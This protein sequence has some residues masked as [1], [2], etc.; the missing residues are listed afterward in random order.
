M[1]LVSFH[2]VVETNFAATIGNRLRRAY[3]A[4]I[5]MRMKVAILLCFLLIAPGLTLA[6]SA[7]P[8][9]PAESDS[10]V[11]VLVP[12]GSSEDEPEAGEEAAS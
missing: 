2:T 10:G 6:Q 8:V 3:G 4:P 9:V 5:T 1:F 7:E 12:A 11:E